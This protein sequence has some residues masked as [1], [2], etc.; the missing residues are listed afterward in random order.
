M[1][2]SSSN[3]SLWPF[4]IY[5]CLRLNTVSV[6]DG[7]A[8][9]NS[10]VNAGTWWLKGDRWQRLWDVQRELSVR[11]LCWNYWWRAAKS[12]NLTE[13]ALRSQTPHCTHGQNERNTYDTHNVLRLALTIYMR[14]WAWS[15][16]AQRHTRRWRA[17]LTH[18]NRPPVNENKWKT[19]WCEGFLTWMSVLVR[20][21]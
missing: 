19:K 10:Q 11:C 1:R 17:S 5:R 9:S 12:R 16:Q 14:V 18:T 4:R 7:A 6:L 20:M 2:N 21:E 13:A 15:K 8:W 3:Q